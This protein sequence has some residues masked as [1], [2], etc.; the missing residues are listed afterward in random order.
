MLMVLIDEQTD[1][2]TRVH[3][4]TTTSTSYTAITKFT[5][6]T[7]P[8]P[9]GFTGLKEAGDYRAKVK[10]RA[11]PAPVAQ[12]AVLPAGLRSG[13]QYVQRVDCVK[14]V[15][16]KVTKVTTATVKGPRITL[17]PKT[18]TKAVKT[19]TTI[20]ETKYPAKV[21]Q[22]ETETVS[23]TVT[24][25]VDRTE[26]ATITETGKHHHILAVMYIY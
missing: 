18:K 4:S 1:Y 7:V 2:E 8:A 24:E 5:S 26:T 21:T 19:T 16:N 6:V 3:T 25:T 20:T 14:R 17:K 10:A 15:P 11:V 9:A 22:T 13:S 12:P 23:P